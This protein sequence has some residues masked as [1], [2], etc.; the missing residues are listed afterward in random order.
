MAT[1]IPGNLKYTKEHEWA[2]VEGD[3]VTIGITDFA[4]SALGDIVF[5]EVPDVGTQLQQGATFGVV[6]SIKS[7]SD[8]YAPVTGEVVAR[9]DG[10]EGSPEKINENAYE[11]WLIKVKVKNSGELAQ[12]LSAQ[13]YETFCQTSA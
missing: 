4:Q 3:V 1:Q 2:L 9:N 8:L 7:V 10:V 13:A 11:S 5:V 6:E 12:L